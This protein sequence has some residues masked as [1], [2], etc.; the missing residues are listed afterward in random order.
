MIL[1]FSFFLGIDKGFEEM[2]PRSADEGAVDL[3]VIIK[4]I[5]PAYLIFLLVFWGIQIGGRQ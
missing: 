1:L 4:Y 5:T 2:H 3:S